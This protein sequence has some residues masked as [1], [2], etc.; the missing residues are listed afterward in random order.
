MTDSLLIV[1]HT[2]VSRVSMSVSVDETRQKQMVNIELN[3]KC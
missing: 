1:V 2:F 3:Y